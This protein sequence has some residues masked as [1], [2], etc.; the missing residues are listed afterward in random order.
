MFFFWR[1][2]GENDIILRLVFIS[3]VFIFIL[4]TWIH[5]NHTAPFLRWSGA[6]PRAEGHHACHHTGGAQPRQETT[7]VHGAHE[8]RD[9][10]CHV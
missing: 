2:I 3:F 4:S 8:P 7:A 5:N 1:L 10:P 9:P 6:V